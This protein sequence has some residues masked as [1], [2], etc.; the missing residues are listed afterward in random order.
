M[1]PLSIRCMKFF[2][3]LLNILFILFGLALIAVSVMNMRERRIRPEQST[4]SR[5]VLSFLLT[6]GLALLVAAV[7]GCVGA[8]RENVK[9]LYAHACFFIFL[10][11]LEAAVAVGGALVSTWVTSGNSLRGQFFKNATIEDQTT[12]AY[13]DRIQAEVMFILYKG[14]YGPRDY[15]SL[16]REIPASCCPEGY[17][18]KEGGARK[19]LHGSCIAERTYYARGCEKVL[20]HKKAYKGNIIIVS[21]VVFIMFEILCESLAV[22]MARTIKSERKRMQQNLQAHFES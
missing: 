12:Q 10:I 19:H 1:K 18:I 3:T 17:P 20:L 15:K 2:L 9:L 21:G 6:V 8:L 4:V 16:Q 5:G 14:M 22:W 7:L 13:W 11:L